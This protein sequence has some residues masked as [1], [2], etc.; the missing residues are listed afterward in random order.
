[1][2]I[3]F[4]HWINPRGVTSKNS[5]PVSQGRKWIITAASVKILKLLDKSAVVSIK[6][7]SC[8]GVCLLISGMCSMI[9]V[10]KW[11]WWLQHK[12]LKVLISAVE[13]L[14]PFLNQLLSQLFDFWVQRKQ[15]VRTIRMLKRQVAGSKDIFWFHIINQDVHWK[16]HASAS[17]KQ[18]SWETLQGLSWEFR[19]K[20][21]EGNLH[22]ICIRFLIR[23]SHRL[24]S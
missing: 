16:D 12:L 18:L 11:K 1:M 17:E 15:G 3:Q 13:L 22:Y 4:C 19:G 5:I 24:Q 14:N 9:P 23:T 2:F 21:E 6:Q 8:A 7:E 20:R 10:V